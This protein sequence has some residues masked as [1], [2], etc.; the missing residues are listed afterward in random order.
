MATTQPT[1]GNPNTAG[2]P[3][4]GVVTMPRGILSNAAVATVP[5]IITRQPCAEFF[6][7]DGGIGMVLCDDAAGQGRL[8]LVGAQATASRSRSVRQRGRFAGPCR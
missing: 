6:K 8:S 4:A 5:L 7:D 3:A 2:G 1:V